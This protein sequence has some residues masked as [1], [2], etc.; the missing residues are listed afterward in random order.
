VPIEDV[1]GAIQDLIKEGKVRHFA[2]RSGRG[3]NTPRSRRANR[4]RYP[5][6]TPSGRDLRPKSCPV[7]RTGY[8]LSPWSPIGTGFL[9]GDIQP[10]TQLEAN[11]ARIL[12]NSHASRKMRYA[13][14]ILSLNCCAMSR[15]AIGQRLCRL[16]WHGTWHVSP[17]I[18]PIP[19]TTRLDHLTENL[20]GAGLQLTA[21]DMQYIEDGFKKIGVLG[22]RFAPEQLAMGDDGTCSASSRVAAGK[23]PLPRQPQ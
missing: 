5:T 18:V 4:H 20:G 9:A 19:G 16:R 15:L 11:D 12:Y 21:A 13:K 14:I 6:N 7:R 23:S 3:D 1:A 2:V 22:E 17:F 10:G 8:W